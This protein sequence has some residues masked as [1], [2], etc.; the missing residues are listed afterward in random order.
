MDTYQPLARILRSVGLPLPH[1]AVPA[2]SARAEAENGRTTASLPERSPPSCI[3][4]VSATSVAIFNFYVSPSIYRCYN[5]ISI[6]IAF[7][8]LAALFLLLHRLTEQIRS[9]PPGPAPA[10]TA[11]LILLLA[12]GT[13]LDETT[14]VSMT[15]Q[16]TPRRASEF[17]LW[18]WTSAGA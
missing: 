18:T 1:R 4:T 13:A 6:F 11:G 5:R 16:P 9:G 15:P 2:A 3:E 8:A 7:F 12:A 17:H 14:P 10:R